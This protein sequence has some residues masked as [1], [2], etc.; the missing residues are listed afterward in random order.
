MTATDHIARAVMA[1][2][3]VV[4]A[5]CH[6]GSTL[7]VDASSGDVGSD[8][9]DVWEMSTEQDLSPVG[10]VFQLGSGDPFMPWTEGGELPFVAGFQGG[11][12]TEHTVLVSAVSFEEL[13]EVIIRASIERDDLSLASG[14]WS[15]ERSEFDQIDDGWVTSLPPLIFDDQPTVG[16]TVVLAADAEL[17][18]GRAQEFRVNVTLV[19]AG[20]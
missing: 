10:F 18:D 7:P 5:G 9:A 3:A 12:H 17:S 1:V 19:E 11:W 2:F 4:V 6:A 8:G 13:D 15:Y 20:Q 14:G 16:E